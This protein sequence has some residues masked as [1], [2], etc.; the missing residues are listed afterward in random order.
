MFREWHGLGQHEWTD[1]FLVNRSFPAFWQ[2]H[3]DLD[4]R[5]DDDALR[6]KFRDNADLLEGLAVVIFHTALES[7]PP[8][9][10]IDADTKINPAK[11]SLS[12]E[13]WEKDGLFSE[14][15]ISLN[16]ARSRTGDEVD[17]VLLRRRQT[18]P[19]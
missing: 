8:E 11:I 10:A 12:V 3:L 1:A 19:A 9:N 14:D 16:E 13:R 15:G 7:L 6:Q 18:T 2:L 4:E 5:F 17:R